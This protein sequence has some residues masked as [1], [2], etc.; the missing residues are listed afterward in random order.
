MLFHTKD[1]KA[2]L[3]IPSIYSRPIFL[4]LTQIMQGTVSVIHMLKLP[5][6]QEIS[7]SVAPVNED[8]VLKST[9]AIALGCHLFC[10]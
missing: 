1:F 4:P 2:R 8:L 7:L 6:E 3:T 5:L 9:K 10:E